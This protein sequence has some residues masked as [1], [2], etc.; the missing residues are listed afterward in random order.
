M[1]SVF[2]TI[3]LLA[4]SLFIILNAFSC[5]RT[6][7]KTV[8]Q[9][10][11]DALKG[12]LSAAEA[13]ITELETAGISEKLLK[14]EITSLKAKI[15]KLESEIKELDKQNDTLVQE[16]ASLE[17][18]YKELDAK[19]EG[20]QKTLAEQTQTRTIN[21]EQ[22]ENEIFVLLNQ[23]REKV[24]VPEFTLGNQLYK[25]AKQNSRAMA[26]S[27]KIETDPAVFYQEVFW[28]AGYESVNTIARGAILIWK[29]NQ[30]RFEHGALLA[31]NK[32]GAVGAY[33]V[34]EI[35]YITFMAASFP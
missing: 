7:E 11:Y 25:Q 33:K 28:A 24:G 21:E 29:I 35:I 26:A 9:E 1:K 18:R 17:A 16:K 12:Q 23:E 13:K 3:A 8:T 4:V 32:Y 22:L 10:E 27:G 2:K 20:L 14:D 34:G 31:S 6:A 19:Y 30:Y 15:E 5:V